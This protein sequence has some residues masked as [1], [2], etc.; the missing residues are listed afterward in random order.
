MSTSFVLHENDPV[1][2]DVLDLAFNDE[3][4]SKNSVVLYDNPLRRRIVRET[5]EKDQDNPSLIKTTLAAE[6]ERDI[7]SEIDYTGNVSK[8]T[9][10][11][12]NAVLPSL[13][14]GVVPAA[15]L[16]FKRNEQSNMQNGQFILQERYEGTVLSNNGLTF[17]ARL[18]QKRQIEKSV[19]VAEIEK[20]SVPEVDQR[21]IE[22]GAIFYLIIGYELSGKGSRRQ[23]AILSFQGFR[24]LS[25]EL[26]Q[27]Y[28]IT[29]ADALGIEN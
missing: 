21:F 9:L 24:K 18:I 16:A 26:I 29:F 15:Q 1:S 13:Q 11:K 22:P 12:A 17:E 5:L 2:L 10:E 23:K 28:K 19:I 6:Q 27:Q 20:A 3:Q 4:Q 14:A 25:K 7:H 8:F